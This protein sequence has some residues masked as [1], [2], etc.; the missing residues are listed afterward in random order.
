MGTA[1]N[2][3]MGVCNVIFGAVDLGFTQGGVKVSYTA[4]TIEKSVDQLDAP[5]GMVVTKQKFEVTVPLAEYDLNKLKLMLPGA[6][7]T[8]LAGQNYMLLSGAAGIDLNSLAQSLKIV[9]LTGTASDI[10]NNTVT[11]F[12]ACPQPKISFSY[13]KDKIRV[14][15][16]TFQAI[17]H[18][19]GLVAFGDVA[20]QG[21]VTP[22]I[23]TIQPAV[24]AIAGGTSV[25]ITGSGFTGKIA[26][27]VTICGTVVT[28][29]TVIND[30]MI[31]CV[32][33]A[34]ASTAGVA[35]IV[36]IATGGSLPSAFNYA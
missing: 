6:T 3:K 5:V 2:V 36:A 25:V 19:S 30:N 20:A 22:I 23:A 11:V 29:L 4:D 14:F 26:A 13:D 1:A 27:N 10:L 17:A 18:V 16:V 9:P 33:G 7:T 32:A 15:E 12:A 21:S 28:G 8:T 35:G 24:G 31:T 34:H